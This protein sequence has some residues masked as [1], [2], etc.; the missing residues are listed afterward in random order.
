MVK[1]KY[2][3][4][5]RGKTPTSQANG[6]LCK[7]LANNLYVLIRSIYELGLAPEFAK[8]GTLQNPAK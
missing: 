3:P 7:L 5:V 2:G 6:V 1:S 4:S 8:I